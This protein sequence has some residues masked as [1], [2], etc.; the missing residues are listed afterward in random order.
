MHL[1]VSIIALEDVNHAVE[2]PLV[3]VVWSLDFEAGTALVWDVVRVEIS[4]VVGSHE[5]SY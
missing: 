1:V 2:L 3:L 4:V 5:F